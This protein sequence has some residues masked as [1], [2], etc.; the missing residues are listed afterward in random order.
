[1]VLMGYGKISQHLDLFVTLNRIQASR[2]AHHSILPAQFRIN[3][4]DIGFLCSIWFENRLNDKFSKMVLGYI[5]E[6][7]KNGRIHDTAGVV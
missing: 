7:T 5:R 2:Q 4:L 6:Q 3:F 1:M